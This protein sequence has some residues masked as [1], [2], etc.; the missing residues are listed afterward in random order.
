MDFQQPRK[1]LMDSL[2]DEEGH[3]I[4]EARMKSRHNLGADT[5][6]YS[7][8]AEASGKFTEKERSAYADAY[9]K[10]VAAYVAKVQRNRKEKE[11]RGKLDA[12]QKTL[13]EA[14]KKESDAWREL[15]A[16]ESADAAAFVASMKEAIA[17]ENLKEV[18]ELAKNYKVAAEPAA[19]K[20]EEIAAAELA[21]LR[22]AHNTAKAAEK[23]A[24]TDRDAAAAEIEKLLNQ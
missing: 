4:I 1:S 21:K 18:V 17:A 6:L 19:K 7:K 20:P 14:A 3:A 15:S 5:G 23:K 2:L 13:D 10:E 11:L 22:T 24:Q 16:V 9:A 12:A 8:A